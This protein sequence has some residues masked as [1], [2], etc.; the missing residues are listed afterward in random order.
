MLDWKDQTAVIVASGPSA[1]TVDLSLAKGRARFI[2]VNNSYRL[3]P[4]TDVLYAHDYKWWKDADGAPDFEGV[5]YAG[6]IRAKEDFGVNHIN[7]RRYCDQILLGGDEIGSCANSGFQAM[8]LAALFGA[9]KIILV[10]FDMES[11]N[12]SHWHG[13]HE[14]LD[15]PKETTFAM[16]RKAMNGA[17]AQIE[18]LGIKVYLGTPSAL[19]SYPYKPWESLW[20]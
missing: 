12:G 16:W 20:N 6:E 2:A 11:R 18:A 1:Q 7:V 15:N 4:W 8:N 13:D 5:K 19:S 3:C 10:G 17:A 14:R 9:R